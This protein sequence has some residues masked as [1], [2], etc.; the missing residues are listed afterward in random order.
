MENLNMIQKTINVLDY[1]SSRPKGA[2][3]SAIAND[4]GYP[5][6]TVFDILKTLLLNDFAKRFCAARD[7]RRKNILRGGQNFCHRFGLHGIFRFVSHC[8]AVP[9]SA[10]G[11]ARKD[12]LFVQK[13]P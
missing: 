6:T 9:C 1:L 5:K 11:Q 2:T 12:D 8:Q 13:A 7:P 3:L 10:R 4:L